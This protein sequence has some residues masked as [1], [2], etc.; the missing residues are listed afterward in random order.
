M[1][2]NG[3]FNNT[4]LVKTKWVILQSSRPSASI[5]ETEN[6]HVLRTPVTAQKSKTGNPET[7]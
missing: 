5:P 4:H 7:C 1:I 2:I 6:H 3:A